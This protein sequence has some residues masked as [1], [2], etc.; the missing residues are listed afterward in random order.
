MSWF[1]P[2]ARQGGLGP[3]PDPKLAQAKH[4]RRALR[5]FAFHRHEA[6]RRT[7]C[8]L[9]DRLGIGRIGRWE[10]ESL[11]RFLVRL[12]LTLHEGLH[13]GRRD[14]PH[15]M[16]RLAD[17]PPLELGATTGFHRNDTAR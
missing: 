10:N 3:Q 7:Q 11:D 14:E 5:L 15:L 6:H 13:V 4:H 17:F 2:A 12:T 16:P 8:G 1:F 9:T